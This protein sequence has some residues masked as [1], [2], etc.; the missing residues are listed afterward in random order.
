MAALQLLNEVG[1][2][3]R[4]ELELTLVY[5]PGGAALPGPQAALEQ[6]YRREL[7]DRD[8]RDRRLI[9]LTGRLSR[10]HQ[11][12]QPPGQH[13]RDPL[14]DRTSIGSQER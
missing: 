11:L 13:R 4:P 5:N 7:L 3:I 12:H 9:G 10:S 2:G 1:Y 6:D 8:W 14:P